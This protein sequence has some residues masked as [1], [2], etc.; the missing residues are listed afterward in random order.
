MLLQ[1]IVALSYIICPSQTNETRTIHHYRLTCWPAQG[2]PTTTQ[3][4]TESLQEI[5]MADSAGPAVVHC[6]AGIGRT[7]VLIAVDIGIQ[8]LLQGDETVDVLRVVS[9][10]RQDRAGAVLTRDQYRFVHQVSY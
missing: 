2:V 5:K 8:A 6:S 7:G 10:L 1:S 4:I 9:T 3:P